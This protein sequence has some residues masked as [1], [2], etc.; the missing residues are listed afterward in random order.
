MRKILLVLTLGMSFLLLSVQTASAESFKLT[1]KL[2]QNSC[3]QQQ[4]AKHHQALSLSSKVEVGSTLHRALETKCHINTGA[5]VNATQSEKSSWVK[6]CKKRGTNTF[7]YAQTPGQCN[8][9]H[10]PECY[11]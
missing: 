10:C 2:M 3:V 11:P 1:V 4:F 6:C 7:C 9:T 5:L 8:S